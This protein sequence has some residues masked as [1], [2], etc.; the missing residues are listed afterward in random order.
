MNAAYRP[1]Q[2]LLTEAGLHRFGLSLIESPP[3]ESLAGIVHSYLQI[4]ASRP[5]PY[6]M[7]PDG[8][9]AVFISPK[10]TR[11]GG[12]QYQACEIDIPA[13]GE[14]FGIRFQAGALRHFF[15]LDLSEITG[16]FVDSGY[17]PCAR[18]SQ[19]HDAVYQCTG[20]EK[21]SQVCEKWLLTQLKPR[22]STRFDQALSLIYHA[23]GSIR[24][25]TL[26]ATLG[27]SSRHLNRVFQ[28]HIGLSTK[29]F[30]Q[31]LRIQHA[32][33]RLFLT[34]DDSLPAAF[35]LGF[36]DQ[37]HLLKEYKQRLLSS[38]RQLRN[39]FMSDFY[40]S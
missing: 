7:I 21:R 22:A 2:P 35:D 33:K 15:E 31:T 11:I 26:A 40:N 4:S 39:R 6:P 5:T 24:I 27:W 29:R 25:H 8:T 10:G 14:Y 38:P 30:S 37:A 17:F 1:F 36:F 19:L 12:T 16:Q 32:C 28:Q 23:Q 34:P 18:F 3:C 9:Q 20:F 13:P